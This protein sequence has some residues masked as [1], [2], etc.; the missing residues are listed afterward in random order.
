M[1][2]SLSPF[3]A[4]IY[5]QEGSKACDSIYDEGAEEGLI[6]RCK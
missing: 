4:E 2:T 3:T 5:A 1:L 6:E